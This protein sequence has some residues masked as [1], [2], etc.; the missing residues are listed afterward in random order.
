MTPL[1]R[2]VALAV[3]PISFLISFAY[4]LGAEDAPGDGFTAGIISSLGLTLAY[5]SFGFREARDRFEWVAFESVLLVGLA[6]TLAAAVL[7]LLTGGPLLAEQ[8]LAFR[9]PVL[10]E[11]TL[12]RGLLFDLGIY[13]VVLGGTMTVIDALEG[14]V[15]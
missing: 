7:P 10:G 11:V 6:V 14:A 3:L 9:L 15:E 2:A 12:S 1:I 5:L 13:L 8:H 4:L